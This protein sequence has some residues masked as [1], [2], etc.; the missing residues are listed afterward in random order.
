MEENIRENI[1][2]KGTR[3]GGASL[4]DPRFVYH[5]GLNVHPHPDLSSQ[6]CSEGIHLARDMVS[7]RRL[8]PGYEEVYECRAGV[9]LAEDSEKIRVS[10]CFVDKK[11]EI[12]LDWSKICPGI[13]LNPICGMD[14]IKEHYNKFTQ[15]DYDKL[16]I[17]IKTDRSEVTLTAKNKVKDMRTVMGSLK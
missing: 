12:P 14:W 11:L 15:D 2:Y 7:L 3:K 1:Y 9:I 16:G 17:T 6:L 10:Y 4:R 13:P 5:M 8:A